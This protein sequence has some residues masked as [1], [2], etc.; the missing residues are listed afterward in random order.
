MQEF[1]LG[2]VEIT[3][4]MS[5]LIL[6]M[7]MLLKFIG[8][9]FTAK[10]R[11][12]LWTLVL[13]RLAV[14]LSF[15]ILP[16]LIEVPVET[17]P[18]PVQVQMQVPTV[19]Y[20]P[21]PQNPV[22]IPPQEPVQMPDTPVQS[23]VFTEPEPEPITWEDVKAYIPH[24][25]LTGA[26]VF[27]LWNLLS[28]LIYTAK[29]L[30]TAKEADVGTQEIYEAV[31]RKK[32]LSHPP[33]LLVSPDV[34]S[35]A[36]FGLIRRRIVLPEIDF[37][38]NGLAGTLSHE[39]THCRRGDLWIKAVCLLAR[40]LHWFNPL[41]HLAAFR[42]EMEM[43]LSCDEAVLAGC[44]ENTRAAYGEVMLDIIKRCRRNRGA[45]TTHFN[46]GKNAVKARFANILY[47]SGKKRG[48][49]LIAVCLVLCLVAG[50][51]V[52][53]RTEDD[54]VNE[55]IKDI[56]EVSTF[57]DALAFMSG[58]TDVDVIGV[59]IQ[60]ISHAVPTEPI[61]LS[62][63]NAE[64]LLGMLDAITFRFMQYEPPSI[65]GATSYTMICKLGNG[66]TVTMCPDGN[67]LEF[68]RREQDSSGVW[69]TVYY[70]LTP[71]DI[72]S[73]DKV[74][75][76]VR[77]LWHDAYS[78]P[79]GETRTVRQILGDEILEA[80]Q[81]ILRL[82]LDGDTDTEIRL[83]VDTEVHRDLLDVL[84]GLILEQREMERG[85]NPWAEIAFHMGEED[86]RYG[87]HVLTK[88]LHIGGECLKI[89]AGTDISYRM[90]MPDGSSFTDWLT[91]WVYSHKDQEGIKIVRWNAELK[92]TAS[93]DPAAI[94]QTFL[95]TV[96]S[97]YSE[98][99]SSYEFLDLD[100]N[101]I[102]ELIVYDLGMGVGE[103]FTIENGEV[104]SFYTGEHILTHYSDDRKALAP[105]SL[106][107]GEYV[108]YASRT[109]TDESRAWAK[110]WFVPSPAAGGY[111]LYSTYGHTT[112]RTDQYFR[113][114]SGEDAVLG[115]FLCVEELK[116]F[117]RDA[118]NSNPEQGWICYVN[119]Q[120]VTNTQYIAQTKAAWADILTRY[121]VEYTD[122]NTLA[123]LA[124]IEKAPNTIEEIILPEEEVPDGI[125][126]ENSEPYTYTRD[127]WIR[128]SLYT[129]FGFRDP[130]DVSALTDD[131]LMAYMADAYQCALDIYFLFQVSSDRMY[132][133]NV[134]SSDMPHVE[135]DGRYYS[136]M[137]NPVFPT[138]ADL[139][140]YM[141]GVLSHDL[142]KQL[143]EMG[144]F[145]D[146]EGEL[147]GMMGARG[148]DISKKTV[149]FSV[150]SRTDTE[151][152]YTAEVEVREFDLGA[153]EPDYVEYHNFIY[154]LT[155]NGWRWTDFY[156]YN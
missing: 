91:E 100:G 78:I 102:A 153:E 123:E 106:G 80:R 27:L 111:V 37:T 120:E 152:I 49:W 6:L 148:T 126:D 55:N 63:E 4:G 18:T 121:G 57:I 147:W 14:P 67:V 113:F 92:E 155:E 101:G 42:C 141:N 131:E 142:T 107:A 70:C 88:Y 36:A 124:R 3:L 1:L 154:A 129:D 134:W 82:S 138:L 118:V 105:P 104:R 62:Q 117:D 29:I 60:A 83:Y 64:T 43:E 32:G 115:K 50:A 145:I 46:P 17:E 76:A 86:Y 38:E 58:Q 103:I 130:V 15:G 51:I 23:P 59:Q 119:G 24:V 31:C 71:E 112:S 10:C 35:P 85:K 139:E 47:G 25:Y 12:I 13:L 39:V 30:R 61:T 93:D 40:A 89:G 72:A 156:L 127:E 149:G 65:Y 110:N 21:V 87:E 137:F 26:A 109:P 16:A 28:Y 90:I 132:A 45:L 48:L 122:E 53:C 9:K 33:V 73:A 77:Q 114:Y 11:Y 128:Y 68:V 69:Q 74:Y 97:P 56:D 8:G 66:D 146:Y 135:I 75:H 84:T 143:L 41:V 7:L 2:I 52:A 5:L 136:Q 94:W 151:I 44:D 81:I 96:V 22:T 79:E 116:R 19:E 98:Y 144:M 95:D 108:F 150:T 54:I 99:I 34:N 125:I 20:T 133:R 140:S